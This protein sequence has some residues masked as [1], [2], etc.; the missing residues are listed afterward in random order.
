MLGMTPTAAAPHAGV[1]RSAVVA[2]DYEAVTTLVGALLRREGL[3]VR[4]ASD[5][6]EAWRMIEEHAPDLLVVD[7]VLPCM[8]G[9]EIVEALGE[10]PDLASVRVAFLVEH[11]SGLDRAALAGLDADA[12]IWKPF[13]LEFVA[14]KL[15]TICP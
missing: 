11:Q 2:D 15:R 3:D 12:I 4:E 7:D 14:M 1:R 5:G 9:V 6:D 13:D 10:R 8:S